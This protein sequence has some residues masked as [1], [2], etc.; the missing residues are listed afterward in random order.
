MTPLRD[1]GLGEL[2]ES[3][4]DTMACGWG[5]DVE[6]F[7][8]V[9][10]SMKPAD[11]LR[12]ERSNPNLIL[13]NG[14]LDAQYAAALCPVRRLALGQMREGELADRC[15]PDLKERCDIGGLGEAEAQRRGHG[16]LTLGIN[17]RETAGASPL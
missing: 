13:R 4:A 14:L 9:G 11:N 15:L 12:A 2:D 10:C 1:V 17:G 7:D 5:R 3:C 8:G 6:A 16:G